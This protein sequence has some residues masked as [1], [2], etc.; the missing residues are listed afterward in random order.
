M[1]LSRYFPRH[2]WIAGL[3]AV[4]LAL[5]LDGAAAQRN[6]DV[7]DKGPKVGDALPH[8][9]TVADQFNEVRDFASLKRKKGLI[10]LFSRSFDW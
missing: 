10:L 5:P 6:L 2:L 9:L 7:L 8:P 1:V 4:L 3:F